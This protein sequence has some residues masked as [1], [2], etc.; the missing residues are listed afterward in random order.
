MRQRPLALTIGEPAG[1]GPD[2]TLK[3]WRARRELRLPPFLVIGDPVS[4]LRRADALQLNVPI[5]EAE[6]E[7]A[8]DTFASSLPVL[9]H[10]EAL[11]AEPAKP[12]AADAPWV[13]AA[14][15]KAVELVREDRCSAVVTNPV[16]K[17]ALYETGFSFPGQTEL[18]AH[19]AGTIDG[20]TRRAVMMI[21]G[22][23]LRTVPVT[24]HVPLSDV[25]TLL[26]REGIVETALIVDAD[27][28]R[29]FGL[30]K[31]RLV[32]CGLNPHAGEDGALGREEI[33]IIAPAVAEIAAHGICVEGPLPADTLF[34]ATARERYDVALGMYHDQAL[35][36]AKAL[37]FEDAV[38][39]TLG[40]PF[41]RTSPDH[42]TAFALS[43]SGKANASSLV[44]ALRMAHEM[45]RAEHG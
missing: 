43:G 4:L 28:R 31:P 32:V 37:G 17:R 21:A 15:E 13:A 22:P 16:H 39:V 6:P 19:L 33:E 8:S 30:E 7:A 23:T 5:V 3:A 36:P 14:I 42:G 2:I 20:R 41:I 45:A 12:H 44:A 29:R 10:G 38:N 27:L 18:L 26:T 24:I 40:L 11:Q 35:V 9:W 1:I 25:P 34:H